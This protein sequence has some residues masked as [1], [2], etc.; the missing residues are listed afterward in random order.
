M[1]YV[2]KMAEYRATLVSNKKRWDGMEDIDF[3]KLIKEFDEMVKNVKRII[4]ASNR[5]G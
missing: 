4:Y 3:D 2:E 5:P 1:T